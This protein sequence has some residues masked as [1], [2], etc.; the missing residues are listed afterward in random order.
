M[1]RLWLL[2]QLSPGDRLNA[3]VY[4]DVERIAQEYPRIEVAGGTPV[5]RRDRTR[6]ALAKAMTSVVREVDWVQMDRDLSATLG[7]ADSEPRGSR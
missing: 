3:R 5:G 1:C 7:L 4:E 2:G 6:S